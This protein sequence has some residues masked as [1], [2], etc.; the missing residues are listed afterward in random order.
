MCGLLILNGYTP[1]SINFKDIEY[2]EAL[3]NFY[4][5]ENKKDTILQKLLNKQKE[6]TKKFLEKK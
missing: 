1:F 6:I 3:V 4:D 2:S 5:D